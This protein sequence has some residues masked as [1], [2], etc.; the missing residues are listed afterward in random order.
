MKDN[1]VL[2]SVSPPYVSQSNLLVPRIKNHL[3]SFKL[4][5]LNIF[6]AKTCCVVCHSYCFCYS[7]TNMARKMSKKPRSIRLLRRFDF[8]QAENRK[9][10]EK[11]LKELPWNQQNKFSCRIFLV[12]LHLQT[13]N[14]IFLIGL[15]KSFQK[16]KTFAPTYP[17][18]L[19]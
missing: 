2:P 4:G 11:P 19:K 6:R 10:I 18:F 3:S 1:S 5:F 16:M 14:L 9:T 8:S 13:L 7:A 12:P 15:K 17:M